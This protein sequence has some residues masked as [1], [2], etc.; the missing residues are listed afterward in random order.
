[1]MPVWQCRK[2]LNFA[3]NMTYSSINGAQMTDKESRD[4]IKLLQEVA[5][6]YSSTPEKAKQFLI[7]SGVLTE[8]G[9]LA[10]PY[11]S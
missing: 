4:L 11:R 5:D 9:E 10:E 3:L 2:S 1:M 7:E 8:S 6:E